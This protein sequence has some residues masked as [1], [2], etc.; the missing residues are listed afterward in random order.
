MCSNIERV[1]AWFRGGE[2]FRD[3]ERILSVIWKPYKNATFVVHTFAIRNLCTARVCMLRCTATV[4]AHTPNTGSLKPF[5]CCFYLILRYCIVFLFPPHC[6]YN[7]TRL[8][9]SMSSV[10]MVEELDCF[11]KQSQ[12]S[13]LDTSTVFYLRWR[14]LISRCCDVSPKNTVQ[15][16]KNKC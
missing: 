12:P 15:Q 10:P 4:H 6:F 9:C 11:Q 13:S 5:E 7:K 16:P 14:H 8:E 1:F 2:H 3:F